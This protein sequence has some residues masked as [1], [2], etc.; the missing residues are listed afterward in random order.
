MRC[1]LCTYSTYTQFL[2]N[3]KRRSLYPFNR[4]YFLVRSIAVVL[5]SPLSLYVNETTNDG[6]TRDR[7][8]VLDLPVRPGF[9]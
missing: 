4:V 3:V 6:S 9:S 2:L 5:S 8:A 1:I 7:V